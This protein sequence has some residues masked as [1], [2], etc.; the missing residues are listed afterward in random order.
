[1]GSG[2]GQWK[3][4]GSGKGQGKSTGSG[5][6][7]STGSGKGTRKECVRPRSGRCGRGRRLD[8]KCCVADVLGRAP[9]TLDWT[10]ELSAKESKAVDAAWAADHTA[11]SKVGQALTMTKGEAAFVKAALPAVLNRIAADPNAIDKLTAATNQADATAL[12]NGD[13]TATQSWGKWLSGKIYAVGRGL[14]TVLGVLAPVL[15]WLVTRPWVMVAAAATLLYLKRQYC[16]RNMPSTMRPTELWEDLQ[17]FLHEKLASYIPW[18]AQ[19][20]SE[21]WQFVSNPWFL[22]AIAAVGALFLYSS[23]VTA[24]GPVGAQVLSVAA[25]YGTTGY[26]LYQLIRGECLG[27][28]N[29]PERPTFTQQDA[30]D[31]VREG[32]PPTASVRR[33]PTAQFN[34]PLI[35]RFFKDTDN[36]RRFHGQLHTAKPVV[37]AE[38]MAKKEELQRTLEHG[39]QYEPDFRLKPNEERLLGLLNF[40]A[41]SDCGR[42]PNSPACIRSKSDPRLALFANP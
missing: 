15:R 27:A 16:L 14:I 19:F 40:W 26:L 24:I 41:T 17:H 10:G 35:A 30:R 7:K 18:A 6:G 11:M 23:L 31:A 37:D 29:P 38:W 33:Q 21:L 5:K 36:G 20:V 32:P 9:K 1:M 28:S 4:T 12:G 8:G 39:L 42:D 3:I 34:D 25:G 2:K 13:P 22:A